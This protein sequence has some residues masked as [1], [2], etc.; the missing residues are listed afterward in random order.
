MS[1]KAAPFINPHP[2]VRILSELDP[3]PSSGGASGEKRF[4]NV[5][6]RLGDTLT[7]VLDEE[8]ILGLEL[9]DGN[10]R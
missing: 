2:S 5:L 4:V 6:A 7:D 1:D 3:S 8:D 9:N 10:G